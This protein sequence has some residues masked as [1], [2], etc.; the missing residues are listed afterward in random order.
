MHRVADIVCGAV[1][2]PDYKE[3]GP[4]QY[5]SWMVVPYDEAGV[6]TFLQVQFIE[7]KRTVFQRHAM[8]HFLAHSRR[9]HRQTRRVRR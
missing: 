9:C 8:T 3:G 4:D 2:C 1:E 5:V 6:G 7:K